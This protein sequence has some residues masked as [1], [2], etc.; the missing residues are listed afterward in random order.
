MC[1]L[2]SMILADL[3]I[4]WRLSRVNVP[5]DL[6][7]LHAGCFSAYRNFDLS[8]KQNHQNFN[9]TPAENVFKVCV[10]LLQH[11]IKIIP[12]HNY[13]EHESISA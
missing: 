5:D 1:T 9:K 2:I 10:Y 7:Y 4:H 8:S 6:N 13:I 12:E 11:I 3:S